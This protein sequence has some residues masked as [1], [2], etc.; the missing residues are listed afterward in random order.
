MSMIFIGPWCAGKSTWGEVYSKIN[1]ESIV[2]VDEIALSYGAELGWSLEHLLNRNKEVGM[3]N[4]EYEWEYIRA[5][6][7]ER[8]LEDYPT[9]I[10][11][12]GASYSCYR[13][14]KYTEEV[15]KR[16]ISDTRSK[17]LVLPSEDKLESINICKR[18]AINSRGTEWVNERVEF[19]SWTASSLDWEVADELLITGSDTAYLVPLEERKK[20]RLMNNWGY[21]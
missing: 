11:S 9:G 18:R 17:C 12:L 1:N 20:K 7:I 4:S 8:V 21:R 13:D 2:D 10:L 16:L 3:L 15:R 19:P 14:G 6:V 5:Y